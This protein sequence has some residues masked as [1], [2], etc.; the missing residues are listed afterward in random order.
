MVAAAVV[1]AVVE[2]RNEWV[3]VYDLGAALLEKP[4][5]IERRAFTDV[6][7][8]LLVGDTNHD[9]PAAIHGLPIVVERDGDLFDD[10]RR[11]LAVD[12]TREVD[13]ARLVVQRSHLPREVVRV[14]WNAVSADAWSRRE[15][16]EP[17]RL[18]CGG[19]D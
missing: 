6:V 10:E 13:E 9:D 4:D 14:Q 5:H 1:V 12:L 19:L 15:L 8:V 17:E 11:H 16:H 18:R 2:P 3:V 7:D